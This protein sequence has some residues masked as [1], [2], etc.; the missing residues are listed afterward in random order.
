MCYYMIGNPS[1]HFSCKELLVFGT[2]IRRKR[3]LFTYL[4]IKINC[5]VTIGIYN[6]NDMKLQSLRK[7][8]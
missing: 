1:L 5:L 4:Q 6:L 2:K 8:K 7:I 3:K